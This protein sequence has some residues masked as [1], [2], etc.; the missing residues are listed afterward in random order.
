MRKRA[1]LPVNTYVLLASLVF[2]II[3]L[4]IPL[5]D[6]ATSSI[7]KIDRNILVS[8]SP[9]F[10]NQEILDPDFDWIHMKNKSHTRYGDYSTNIESV[11][12]HSNGKTLDAILW[13]YFPFQVNQSRLNDEVNYGMY[14]D[15][16]FNQRT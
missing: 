14:I 2:S 8:P 16:D 6:N 12:Y 10:S 13:L 3:I 7:A 4:Y 9:S 1:K 11:D 5:I 15:A